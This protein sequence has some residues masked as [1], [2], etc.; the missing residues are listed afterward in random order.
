MLPGVVR[1]TFIIFGLFT[2]SNLCPPWHKILATPLH[3][4]P[5]RHSAIRSLHGGA[6]IS[7]DPGIYSGPS[8]S[9]R[10]G[11]RSQLFAQLY[12]ANMLFGT[13]KRFRNLRHVVC[14]SRTA[15]EEIR[16]AYCTNGNMVGSKL[17]GRPTQYA[18]APCKL[19]FDLLT[20]KV[21]FESLEKWPLCQF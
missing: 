10:S 19:T 12:M 9:V 13:L 16:L 2:T 17:C 15:G 6:A 4:V 7:G 1:H 21:V 18:P 11:R 3:S 8:A 14:V 5:Y 20:L